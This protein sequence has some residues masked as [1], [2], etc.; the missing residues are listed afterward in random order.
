MIDWTKPVETDEA[1][2]RKV[3]V[4]CTDRDAACPVVLLIKNGDR[5]EGVYWWSDAGSHAVHYGHSGDIAKLRN[6]RERFETWAIIDRNGF[7]CGS[8]PE[9]RAKA[10]AKD[11]EGRA[12]L[13]REVFPEEM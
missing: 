9:A 2:P 10:W 3:R 5:G 8:M 13:L 4:I 7:Y 12:V 1:K 6:V 11:Y